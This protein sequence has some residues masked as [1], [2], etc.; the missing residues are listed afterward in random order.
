MKAFIKLEG[1]QKSLASYVVKQH[2]SH[3]A[4]PSLS[5]TK[6]HWNKS[7]SFQAMKKNKAVFVMAPVV[8]VDYRI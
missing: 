2:D 6:N 7:L 8:A 5:L 1:T 3:F 4:K